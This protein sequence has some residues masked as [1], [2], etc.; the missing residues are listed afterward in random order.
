[1]F[2]KFLTLVAAASALSAATA[3]TAQSEPRWFVHIGGGVVT[4]DERA[5]IEAGGAPVP[6]ADVSI[7]LVNTVVVE[8]GRHITDNVAVAFAGGLPPKFEVQSAG[9]L[10]A[11]GRDGDILGGPAAVMVQYHLTHLERVQPYAGVGVAMLYVFDTTDGAVTQVEVDNAI[12]PLV[13]VGAVY[14][15]GR[16][17]GAFADYKKSWITTEARG[18]LG[19]APIR[20]DVRLDPAVFS[21]GLNRRF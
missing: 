11:L 20:A 1:M 2:R 3:A 13:Q 8:I 10:S 21:I 14:R 16:R 7:D 18:F 15:V 19:P 17:W 5:D 12:G 9:T 4:V 6:G